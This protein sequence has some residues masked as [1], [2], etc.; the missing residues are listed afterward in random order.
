MK[1]QA[2]A[3]SFKA[4]SLRKRIEV[5]KLAPC[6]LLAGHL[7]PLLVQLSYLLAL[8]QAASVDSSQEPMAKQP[9]KRGQKA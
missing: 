5:V 9:E 3:A 2:E 7:T 4:S 8:Y 1:A 6:T